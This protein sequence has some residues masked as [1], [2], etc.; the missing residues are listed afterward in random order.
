MTS[1]PI[2]VL[3]IDDNEVVRMGLEVFLET[4]DD[5]E[6]VGEADNGEA[7]VALCQQLKP[8]VVIVDFMM[9]GMDGIDTV[10]SLRKLPTHM[11]VLMLS[12]FVDEEVVKNVNAV[13]IN[14]YILKENSIDYIAEAI[15][16]IH[17]GEQVFCSRVKSYMQKGT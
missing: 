12:A 1:H 9:P 16:R 6:L 7:G 4:R 15:R 3:I 2:R 10:R 17:A 14:G 13:N 8:D 11:R 5:M